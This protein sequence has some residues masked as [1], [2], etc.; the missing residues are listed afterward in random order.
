MTG[1]SKEVGTHGEDQQTAAESGGESH[2]EGNAKAARS[3]KDG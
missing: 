1:S 2:G 3:E